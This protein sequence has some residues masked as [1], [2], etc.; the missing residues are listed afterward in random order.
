MGLGGR[1]RVGEGK[2][3]G[4]FPPIRRKEGFKESGWNIADYFP[5]RHSLSTVSVRGA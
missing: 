4:C 2:C 1:G 3:T 5:S